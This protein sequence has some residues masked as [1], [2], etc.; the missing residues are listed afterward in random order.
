[1]ENPFLI[2]IYEENKQSGNLEV[3][4]E[5]STKLVTREVSNDK[6]LNFECQEV[7]SKSLKSAFESEQSWTRRAVVFWATFF[8]QT[9][10]RKR[11]RSEEGLS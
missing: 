4:A 11:E 7:M 9:H 8:Y 1:M 3:F 10:N 6:S 2:K 5:Q